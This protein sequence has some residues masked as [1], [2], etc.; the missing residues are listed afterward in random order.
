VRRE[1]AA[2]R[3]ERHTTNEALDDAAEALRANRDL[4][5][6]LKSEASV[7]FAERAKRETSPARRRAW[8]LL[9]QAEDS[10][11]V[12]ESL[13]A[14]TPVEDPHDSP[15]HHTYRVPRD[16]PQMGGA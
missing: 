14:M 12:Y 16:L 1:V 7:P 11:R 5:A 4:I 10:E 2:L 15:L 9:A 13:A 8:L 3:A 6:A